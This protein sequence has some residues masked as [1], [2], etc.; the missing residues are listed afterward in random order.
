MEEQSSERRCRAPTG[1]CRRTLK[2]SLRLNAI[3][4]N[5]VPRESQFAIVQHSIA[6]N[7][8]RT[9]LPERTDET[10]R[11]TTTITI[12]TII[13]IKT[14]MA[15]FTTC[16]RA[17]YSNLLVTRWHSEGPNSPLPRVIDTYQIFVDDFTVFSS[18]SVMSQ[19]ITF[20]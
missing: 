9:P 6:R 15:Y 4:R 2:V 14:T 16:S 17:G 5:H 1:R 18:L 7:S 13:T 20:R 19:T 8:T 3:E 11:V 12:I 10:R